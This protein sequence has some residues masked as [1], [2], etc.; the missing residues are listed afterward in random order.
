MEIV[1]VAN[2]TMETKPST[3]WFAAVWL[4]PTA[5]ALTKDAPP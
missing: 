2:S 1:G 5:F 4:T 3:L